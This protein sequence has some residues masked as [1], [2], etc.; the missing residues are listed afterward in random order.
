MQVQVEAV[1]SVEKKIIVEV[2]KQDVDREL[3]AQYKRI[4]KTARV[5]GFRPGKVP[6]G[7]IKKM[8]GPQALAGAA[9][10]LVRNNLS[11]AVEESGI[12]PVAI[13]DMERGTLAEGTDFQFTLFCQ[14]KPEVE[15][16]G[17][18]EITV[19]PAKGEP[20]VEEIEADLERQR[21]TQAELEPVED[22]DSDT[23]DVLTI[24]YS[25]V[26]DGE[27]EPFEGGVGTDTELELGSG[28]FVPGFEDQLIGHRE[29][30]EV[31]VE[32]TL[33]DDYPEH[34]AGKKAIFTTTVKAVSK[35]VIPD[36]DDE[37]AVDLGF[38]DMGDMRAKT[39]DRLK[40]QSEAAEKNRVHDQV[41]DAL[42]A[43]NEVEI[44]SALAEEAAGR[45]REQV[46]SQFNY[47]GVDE[48]LVQQLLGAQEERIQEQAQRVARRNLLLEVI[49]ADKGLTVSDE[50]IDERLTEMSE[51]LGQP[52]P[53][54]KALLAQGG[55]LNMLKDDMQREMA[56]KWL[57]DKATG[58]LPAAEES[59]EEGPSMDKAA[60][61]GQDTADS[62]E[63]S[64][65][66]ATEV[67][68]DGAASDAEETS[69]DEDA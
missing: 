30:A 23:G 25:G 49:A 59:G 53:K 44:P 8:Y 18:D 1:S 13:P 17:I 56:M 35:R 21:Q 22:R 39:Y 50:D 62:A 41:M 11:Q 3:A 47:P 24:D 46:R 16:K 9:E 60:D 57:I 4:S 10:E 34:L 66:E 6:K 20:S 52:K 45:I 28:R 31:K 43:A 15:L 14:V 40:E 29:G 5:R 55:S 64:S 67:A 68:S 36:L 69:T 32:V 58:V 33:P 19:E 63:A 38:E 7:L 37:L 54:I 42:L 48:S 61:E 12:E 51:Q 27:A 65:E 26:L 2:P